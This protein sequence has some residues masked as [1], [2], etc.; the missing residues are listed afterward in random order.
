VRS[1]RLGLGVSRRLFSRL[2]GF[3]D[4]AIAS[5]E[6]GR[7]LSGPSR[8]RVLEM[9]RLKEALTEVMAAQYVARWMEK[10]N[11]AF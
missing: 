2:T 1:T 5:W 4:R 9:R 7:E 6:S 8:Q 3:S 11:P 10:S